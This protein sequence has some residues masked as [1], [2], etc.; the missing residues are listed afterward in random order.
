MNQ[1]S[2]I[3]CGIS[4]YKL[5]NKQ[6]E[7]NKP[8]I[9]VMEKRNKRSQLIDPSCPFDTRVEEKEEEKCTNDIE[10]EYELKMKW[11]IK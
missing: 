7:H 9:T 8:D 1:I 3:Y 6:I 11:K 10:L 2:A 4:L 5:T